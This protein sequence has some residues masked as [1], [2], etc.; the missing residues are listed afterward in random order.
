M[1][2]PRTPTALE[3]LARLRT[4]RALFAGEDRIRF[5][6]LVSEVEQAV[7]DTESVSLDLARL[8]SSGVAADD[9]PA[10]APVDLADVIAAALRNADA[11]LAS[12]GVLIDIVAPPAVFVLGNREH[13]EPLF[14]TA[15]VIAAS[16]VA[17]R[18]HAAL[19][20][21]PRDARSVD[22]SIVP[23]RTAD[24]RA[25][26]VD[27]LARAQ[28]IQLATTDDVLTMVLP[29]AAEAEPARSA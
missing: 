27:A 5:E 23:F 9:T 26:I 3:S 2:S 21:G 24:P 11:V 25:L 16:T 18:G 13:L 28:H 12:R 19:R 20:Y 17:P 6:R 8:V 1:S 22:L 15:L 7:W 10:S 4:M 29:A 14:S